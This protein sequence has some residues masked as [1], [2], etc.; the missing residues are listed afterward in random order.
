MT[1]QGKEIPV[2]LARGR[3]SKLTPEVVRQVHSATTE[4]PYLGSQRLVQLIAQAT[5]MSISAQTVNTIRKCLH[6]RY[7][8]ARQYPLITQL[9]QAKRVKFY[10][11]C[12]IGDIDWRHDVI[13]S[14][15]SRFRLS[16]D[17][18]SMWIQRGVYAERTFH[19]M[20]KHNSSIMA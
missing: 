4:D 13:I 8:R 14:D 18:R 20:P 7:A 12:L 9:Q 15:E 17:S 16:D 1:G 6:F 3:L 2:C 11:E 5:E 19:P 10:H